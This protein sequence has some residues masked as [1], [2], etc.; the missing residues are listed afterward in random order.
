MAEN[1][2]KRLGHLL[3]LICFTIMEAALIMESQLLGWDTSAVML[4]LFGLV[5]SWTLHITG[6]LEPDLCLWLYFILTMLAFFY[7]GTHETSIYDLA[8]TII[9]FIL[10]LSGTNNSLLPRLCTVTYFFTMIYSLVFVAKN[11]ELNSLNVTRTGL[12]FG[13]VLIADWLV[14]SQRQERTKLQKAK[15]DKVAELKE[16]NHKMENFL[17]NVSHELR[18]PINAI[19]GFTSVI[20]DREKDTTKRQD[21]LSIQKAGHR[22][23][24]QIE[25]ILDYTEIDTKSIKINHDDYMISSIVNDIVIAEQ[26]RERENST[27]IIFDVDLSMPTKLI[28]DAR[29]IKKITKHLIDN[30]IKFTPRGAVLVEIS[31]RKKEYG[32]NLCISVT[33]TG[34]GIK[35]ENIKK[36]SNKFYQQNSERNRSA[37]GLGL[38]L[39]IVYGI[40]SAMGGFVRIKSTEGEGSVVSVSIPQKISEEGQSISVENADDLCIACYLNPE[41][42]FSTKVFSF[43]GN[44]IFHLAQNL[45]VS[46]HRA[47]TES[48]L[49]R[50]LSKYR[51]THLF[52]GKEEYLDRPSYYES[53][54]GETCVIMATDDV[55]ALPKNSKVTPLK[56]PFYFLPIID[57]L[58]K[59][60]KAAS[61]LFDTRRIICPN[62]KALIVDDEPM[63]LMVANEILKAYQ[64][65]VKTVSSGQKAIAIC[66]E[67]DFD[68]I[69]LDHMMPEMDGIETL[70]RLRKNYERKNYG[71][72]NRTIIVAFTAN[73]VSGAREMFLNAGFDEFISKPIELFELNRVLKKVLPKS[74][75]KYLS[76]DESLDYETQKTLVAPKGESQ[77]EISKGTSAKALIDEQNQKDNLVTPED[78]LAILER[79]GIHTQQGISYSAGDVKFYKK[80]LT[81][82]VEETPKEIAKIQ[83]FLKNADWS[84][85]QILVHALKST[86]KMIGADE[87]SGMAK[88]AEDAA[89]ATDSEYIIAHDSELMQKYSK[90]ANAISD[91]LHLERKNTNEK[92]TTTSEETSTAN[93]AEISTDYFKSRLLELKNCLDTFEA[94]RAE[95]MIAEIKGYSYDGK[96]IEEILQEI[97]NDVSSF[98]L[99][100]ASKKVQNLFDTLENGEA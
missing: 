8:P 12:H 90:T 17:V 54:C 81:S 70:K 92:T 46:L 78:E 29:K 5:I 13:L 91:A 85:Y 30:A 67:E 71:S 65:K 25:D 27:E 41:K 72:R 4:L 48:E 74:V 49:E 69:F 20:L 95:K 16:N 99:S 10:L 50:I 82:F 64:M 77:N 33:D 87:L 51:I 2:N 28:G 42:Y 76:D 56:K 100:T 44:M 73:A 59:S 35:A 18:T 6:W 22:L 52:I 58:N 98:D 93:S 60:N 7:Y 36:L 47:E 32:I 11:I 37:S 24:D 97:I 66:L 26:T 1:G 38:G 79:A 14:R 94:E 57:I 88:E 43:Y 89:K 9:A 19:M 40:V 96:H 53:L 55:C 31:G 75:I 21:I 61:D 83:G 15:D 23:F 45:N 84:S 80:I 63:N 39:S 86:A 34:V 3:V 68:I 62:V